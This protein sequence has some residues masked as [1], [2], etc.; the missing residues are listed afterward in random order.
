MAGELKRAWKGR[1]D[2]IW[3]CAHDGSI[4]YEFGFEFFLA[5]DA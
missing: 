5:F 3:I 2:D 1:I 4:E